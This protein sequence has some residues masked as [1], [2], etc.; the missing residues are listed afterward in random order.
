MSP[1]PGAGPSRSENVVAVELALCEFGFPHCESSRYLEP[2]QGLPQLMVVSSAERRS[3]GAHIVGLWKAKF[4][5]EGN[6]STPDGTLI[7]SPF[8]QS[9][10]DGAEIMNSTR[11]PAT[12]SF[13]MGVW[14][15][16][17]A[18]SYVLNHFALSFDSNG[19]FVG[20]ARED[21]ILA[22]KADH[23]R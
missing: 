22:K 10:D 4:V 1:T 7:D 13:C 9:H 14:H 16:S 12:Q 11:A 3:N 8:V 23:Y 21:I 19:T 17:G 6:S 2:G 20:P 5:A 18:V 15:K